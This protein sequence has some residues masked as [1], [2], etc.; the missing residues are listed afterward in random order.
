M[1][2]LEQYKELENKLESLIG[3]VK[4]SAEINLKLER[5]ECLLELLGNP[6]DSFSV[7]HV[8]GTSG[9]GSTSSYI[10][11]ILESDGYKTGL[12]LSPY[13][14]VLNEVCLVEGCPVKTSE[15]LD[16]Y[17]EIEPLFMEVA[18][19][20]KF[21]YPSYF[22]VK[23]ALSLMLFKRKNID[24]A[25]IEVGIGGTLDASNVLST[26]VSVLVSVGL[27][28]TEI[29]GDTIEEI[30]SDKVGIIKENG[31]V[32]CGFSQE[33]TRKIALKRA[34]EKKATIFLIDRNFKYIYCN[35]KT[36][37]QTENFCQ[38]DL[39]LSIQGEHQAHNASCAIVAY[40]QFVKKHSK[41]FSHDAVIKGLSIAKIPGRSEIIQNQPTV[42]LDGAHNPDKLSSFLKWLNEL[43]AKPIIIMA[44]K[45]GRKV[46]SEIPPI[47]G[48]T[49]AKLIIATS[50]YNQGIWESM[51]SEDL[52]EEI[53]KNNNSDSTEVVKIT[54][55]LDAIKY[56][57]KVA[58][59][60]D[61]IAVTGSLFLVGDVREYWHPKEAILQLIENED[62]GDWSNDDA[63]LLA[64]QSFARLDAE[65][66][67]D[68]KSEAGS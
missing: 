21:G 18:N 64:A 46:N 47:L 42:I 9:K 26:D 52:S 28:H 4:F 58:H 32:V 6:Q 2:L 65:E 55:P 8:G 1:N 16:A 22:E 51:S 59:T 53:K 7:I 67:A 29:L 23:L 31:T 35:G 61:V 19:R 43:S 45:K 11:S 40:E 41:S 38:H 5:I 68:G 39:N 27:D 24:V 62:Y 14:Q 49:G 15:L 44:L 10:S 56:A 36:S 17:N 20:T 66:E 57:L 37:I 33:S 60:D 12:F 48:N 63:V 34:E 50:F 13:L 54:D 30:A 25:V 3:D